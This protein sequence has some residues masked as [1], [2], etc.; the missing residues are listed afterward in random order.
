MLVLEKRLCQSAKISY[1][2][3]RNLSLYCVP[4]MCIVTSLVD[5]YVYM[6]VCM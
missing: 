6:Y 1:T 5:M 4:K 2:L 3:S